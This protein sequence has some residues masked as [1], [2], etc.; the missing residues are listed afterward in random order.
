M[1]SSMQ[2]LI[3]SLLFVVATIFNGN[4]YEQLD[5]DSV[6]RISDVHTKAES[7]GVPVKPVDLFTGISF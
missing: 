4:A 3:G 7:S 1:H 2:L 5:Y 6:L